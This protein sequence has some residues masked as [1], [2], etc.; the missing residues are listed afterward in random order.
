[1]IAFVDETRGRFG[2]EPICR[3][4]EVYD[5]YDF[6]VTGRTNVTYS[7]SVIE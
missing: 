1:V 5:M 2:V 3:E 7:I 6:Y 4:I